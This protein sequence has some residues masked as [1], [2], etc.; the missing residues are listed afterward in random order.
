MGN[1]QGGFHKRERTG[2]GSQ[3]RSIGAGA[4]PSISATSTSSAC[5]HPHQLH[6]QASTVG[7]DGCPVQV[8]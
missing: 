3:R 8:I 6:S 5:S 4:V 7:D 1:N 2:D